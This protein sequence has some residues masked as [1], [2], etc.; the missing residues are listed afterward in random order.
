M[1]SDNF[2]S[3]GCAVV[4]DS[5]L[6]FGDIQTF[7][8]RLQPLLPSQKID[9]KQIAH[10]SSSEQS[11][12]LSLLDKYYMCFSDESGLCTL[13]QHEIN[14]LPGFKPKRLKAYRV[15]ERLKP[16]V[17]SEIQRML[18]L[19]I[20][21]DMV[22]PLVV[23]LKGPDGKGGLRLAVDYTYLN[24][25]TRHD[26]F[27]VGDIESIINRVGGTRMIS[28]FDTAV[29]YHQTLVRAEDVP[30]TAFVCDD[31]VF[32]FLRTPF[33]GRSCGSTFIRAMQQVLKPIMPFLRS[34]SVEKLWDLVGGALILQK[35]RLYK[36]SNL[37]KLKQK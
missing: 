22:S 36:V 27:P 35:L 6:D 16:Q 21:N 32:E 13:V 11:Q 3:Y 18:E 17:S 34:N 19:G 10:L 26:P 20:I 2:L 8:Q 37:R 31:G 7:E 12:L 29:A 4:S 33:G 1:Q 23:V 24:S 5:D 25:F 30:L 9:N 14:L 15:P 28:T